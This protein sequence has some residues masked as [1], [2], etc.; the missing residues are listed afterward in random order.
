MLTR[1][2]FIPIHAQVFLH[3]TEKGIVDIRLVDVLE[4][5]AQGSECQDKC[6]HLE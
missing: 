6:I 1:D 3:S 4:E 5:V 2:Q